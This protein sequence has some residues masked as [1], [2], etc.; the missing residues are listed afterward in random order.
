MFIEQGRVLKS[1]K[2]A[3]VILIYKGKG[4]KLDVKNYRPIKFTNVLCKTLERMIRGK[5]KN[6]MES[7]A[8]FFPAR[9][10]LDPGYLP[11][12]T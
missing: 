1:W 12:P 3:T 4:S 5:I 2:T 9:L 11:L 10:T 7:E 6:H 8:L